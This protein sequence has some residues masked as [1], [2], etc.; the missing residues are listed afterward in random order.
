MKIFNLNKNEWLDI[1]LPMSFVLSIIILSGIL[2]AI[3]SETPEYTVRKKCIDN[4]SYI[5]YNTGITVQFDTNGNVIKC[6]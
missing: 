6:E 2:S 1:L 3:F 5:L 4:V